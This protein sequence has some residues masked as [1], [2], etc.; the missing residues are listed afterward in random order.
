VSEEARKLMLRSIRRQWVEGTPPTAHEQTEE[1]FI[2]GDD[3]FYG[4]DSPLVGC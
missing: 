1:T 4:L 2:D 3:L